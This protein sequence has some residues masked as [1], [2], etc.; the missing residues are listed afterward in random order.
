MRW[1]SNKKMILLKLTLVWHLVHSLTAF[2]NHCLHQVPKYFH[3]PQKKTPCLLSSFSLVPWPQPLETTDLRSVSVDSP[4]L[5][6]LIYVE[7]YHTW[8]YVLLSFSITFLS[9]MYII[10][11]VAYISSSLLFVAEQY[12]VICIYPVLFIHSST[13][14]HLGC[15]HPLAIVNS[16]VM[17]KCVHI[18]VGVLIF[19]SLGYTARSGIAE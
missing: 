19:N 7:P 14:G 3:H 4:I 6:S 15:F 1:N 2:C 13:D 11:N 5:N 9:I 10:H 12:S 18:F 8:F 17:N 16:A